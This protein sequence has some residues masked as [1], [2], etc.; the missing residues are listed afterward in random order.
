MHWKTT[1]GGI[2]AAIGT[3]LQAAAILPPPWGWLA[4]LLT[5]L[6]SIILGASAADKD[7]TVRKP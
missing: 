3:A 1:I 5:A 2:V 7:L 4:S 6:G